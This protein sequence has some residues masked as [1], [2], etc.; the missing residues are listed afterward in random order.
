[1]VLLATNVDACILSTLE[2]AEALVSLDD[3]SDPPRFT[4]VLRCVSVS[5]VRVLRV[6]TVTQFLG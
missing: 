6:G 1:M 4:R 3:G 5:A 2:P